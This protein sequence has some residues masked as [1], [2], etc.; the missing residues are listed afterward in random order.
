MTTLAEK[1]AQLKDRKRMLENAIQELKDS[2]SGDNMENIEKVIKRRAGE[3]SNLE[4]QLELTE[5]ALK[6][7]QDKLRARQDFEASKEYAD[8]QKMR[9]KLL[10]QAQKQAGMAFEKLLELQSSIQETREL[11]QQADKILYEISEDKN[12]AS[13]YFQER[14]QPFS[15]L[16]SVSRGIH[17]DIQE[18]ELLKQRGVVE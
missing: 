2:L 18:M 14:A 15:W 13:Y 9:E 4:T 17:S 16:W 12:T 11:V 10:K 6:S 5:L 1:E 8:K 7:S 3:I